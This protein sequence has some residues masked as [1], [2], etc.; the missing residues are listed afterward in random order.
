MHVLIATSVARRHLGRGRQHVTLIALRALPSAVRRAATRLPANWPITALALA[1]SGRRDEALTHLE[2]APPTNPVI[3]AALL[4]GA[5]NLPTPTH[6]LAALA[7]SRHGELTEALMHATP[8]TPLHRHLKADLALLTPATEAGR[9]GAGGSA[10]SPGSVKGLGR[11]GRRSAQPK[12]TPPGRRA[13]P[14]P[15]EG[16][17]PPTPAHPRPTVLHLT[18]NALPETVAGY[19]LRTHGIAKAQKEQGLDVHVATRLGFP[20]TKGH[21]RARATE[22]IDGVEYH[23]LLATVPARADKALAKDIERTTRLVERLSPDVLHAHTNHLN[24]QVALAVRERTGIPVVYEVRGFLEETRRSADGLTS[25]TYLLAQQAET[26]CMQQADAVVTLSRTMADAIVARGID[27]AKITVVPNGVP[28]SLLAGAMSPQLRGNG[29]LTAGFVGTLN[30]YEGVDVLIR[31]VAKTHDV[32]LLIVGDG[33]ARAS[34]EQQAAGMQVTF[35]GR[36]APSEVAGRYGEIDVFCLPRHD[37]PVTRLVQPLKPL[38]A[39][40]LGRPVIASDLPPLREIVTDETGRLVPPDDD[41]ALA[42]AL[43]DL[44]DQPDV[45]HSLGAAARD[46][47]AANRTWSRAASTYSDLYAALATQPEVGEPA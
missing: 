30:D 32:R 19:T 31:A 33:P 37:L 25:E 2:Q 28:D 6:R 21:L 5:H 1:A 36:V 35:T 7:A 40:A 18:T 26:W 23:R 42:E 12:A 34:L 27:P 38:E 43:T 8:G 10:P 3:E 44:A 45:R 15:G 41:A 20:V 17:E 39:M 16:A 11:G 13:A 46:W 29:P 9:A 47:V 14:A 22:T 4:L 24:G